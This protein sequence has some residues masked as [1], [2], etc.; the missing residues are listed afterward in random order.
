VVYKGKNH[1][2]SNCESTDTDT[3]TD[4]ETDTETEIRRGHAAA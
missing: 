4:T 1:R 3:D 2:F